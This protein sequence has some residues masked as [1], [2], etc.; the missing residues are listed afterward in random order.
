LRGSAQTGID[1]IARDTKSRKFDEGKALS[2][3][4]RG[5]DKKGAVRNERSG[6]AKLVLR[7]G[8]SG[9]KRRSRCSWEV[10]EKGAKRSDRQQKRLRQ[11]KNYYLKPENMIAKAYS[12][13]G[14][15]NR[16]GKKI[17]TERRTGGEPRASPHFPR[18]R[19]KA[20]YAGG[21]EKPRRGTRW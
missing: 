2:R 21:R 18:K 20:G 4:L 14:L 10:G 17:T 7:Q 3:F 12:G 1:R 6:L 15:K 5:D 11:R 16:D 13:R 19:K 8:S 9:R